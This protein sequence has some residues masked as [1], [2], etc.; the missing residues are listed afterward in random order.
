[1]ELEER[2]RRESAESC[3]ALER[4]NARLGSPDSRYE[5]GSERE[6]IARAIRVALHDV[7]DGL[8]VVGAVSVDA[9]LGEILPLRLVLSL[10]LET[11]RW[12]SNNRG[13]HPPSRSLAAAGLPRSGASHLQESGDGPGSGH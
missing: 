6:G 9:R 11:E 13:G 5:H 10:T 1:M 2:A 7:E 4:Q 8:L 12:N 3:A